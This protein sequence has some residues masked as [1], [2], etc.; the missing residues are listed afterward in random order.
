MALAVGLT[1]SIQT[2]SE[3]TRKINPGS[4]TEQPWD[5]GQMDNDMGRGRVART[6]IRI[7]AWIYITVGVG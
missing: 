5:L 7:Y 2:H 6:S 3:S 4:A 1:Q